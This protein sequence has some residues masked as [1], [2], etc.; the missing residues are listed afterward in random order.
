MI[1][2]SSLFFWRLRKPSSGA[3]VAMKWDAT[4]DDAWN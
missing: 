2:V 1:E 3:T 4:K